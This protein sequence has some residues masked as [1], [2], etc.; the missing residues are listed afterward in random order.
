[1]RRKNGCRGHHHKF[2]VGNGHA[3]PLR[4]LLGNFQHVD[5]LGDAVRLHIILVHVGL[6]QDHV[7]GVE[8]PAVCVKERDDLE[9]GH[10]HEEGVGVLEVVEP[11]LVDGL[12]EEFFCSPLR[13]LI[14]GVVIEAGFVG[15]FCTDA[16]DSR[17]IVRDAGA[18]KRQ[19]AR[20]AE[21]R[22]S[23]VGSILH[24]ICEDCREGLD[25]SKLVVGDFHEDGK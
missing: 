8:A 11:D 13:R 14:T 4:L 7:H 3:R 19:A 12:A 16:D 23:M 2:N 15:G 1:L 10:L 5:V 6:E 20:T 24:G 9:G 18:V 21:E 22:A 25:P 17:G